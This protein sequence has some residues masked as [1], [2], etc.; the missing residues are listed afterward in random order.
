[1]ENDAVK[2]RRR[3]WLAGLLSFLVPGLGQVYNGQETKGLLF[4][5]ALSVWGGIFMFSFYYL[6]KPPATPVHFALIAFMAVVSLVFWLY[7]LFEAIRSAKRISGN[8]ILKGFN[9]WYVYVIVIIV[10]R[11]VNFSTGTVIVKKIIFKAFK[12][13]AGS[14][15]PTI[16]VGDHFICDLSYYRLNN[17][18]RGDIIIFKWPVDESKFFIKRIIGI[19][20]DTIRIVDDEVY[21]NQKKLDLKFIKKYR[22][23]DGK[24]ADI[25]EETVDSRG[26]KVLYQEKKHEN[27]GPVKVPDGKYFVLG[28][29]RDNSDDSRYWGYVKRRQI[30]GRPVFIYFSWNTKIPAWNIFG[31]IASIRFSRFGENLE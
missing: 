12:A 24:E 30:Y 2:K 29:N 21:V 8:Y 11:L 15:M 22:L 18:E 17:P 10:I 6:I 27:F 28:D 3:W 19:P 7:I 5:V 26:Y 14:M 4:Y 13:P 23:E 31:R 20:G 9:R 25:C 1:M 16:D